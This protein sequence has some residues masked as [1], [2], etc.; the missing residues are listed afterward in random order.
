MYIDSPGTGN[1]TVRKDKKS[2]QNRKERKFAIF[3]N[4]FKTHAT[5]YIFLSN[6]ICLQLRVGCPFPFPLTSDRAKAKMPLGLANNISASLE[7]MQVDVVEEN[8]N[9]GLALDA[10]GINGPAEGTYVVENPTLDLEAHM[11]G[12][13]IQLQ[14]SPF[15]TK[16]LLQ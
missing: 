10:D 5:N 1:E 16:K 15:W 4:I 11:Q 14:N 13:F 7:P 6:K 3:N 9:E 12:M 2:K 8:E